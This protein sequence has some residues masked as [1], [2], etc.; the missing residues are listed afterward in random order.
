MAHYGICRNGP[1]RSEN[2]PLRRGNAPLHWQKTAPLKGANKRSMNISPGLKFCSFSQIAPR[3]SC[4]DCSEC[5]DCKNWHACSQL[6][7]F[8]VRRSTDGALRKGPPFHGSRS[9]REIKIQ[10]ASC[11]M[12]DREVTRW[13]NCFSKFS[14]GK[15]HWVVASYR[16]I[17]WHRNLPWNF[18]THGFLDPSAFP[19]LN[20][21]ILAIRL[22][23]ESLIAVEDAAENRGLYRVF[24]SRLF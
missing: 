24:V 4:M 18:T 11:Q 20:F 14:A 21:A 1:L 2:G 15:C 6:L 9:A 13:W 7:Q 17:N 19:E 10:N 22:V 16:E 5:S 12:G 23:V 8:W 3:K